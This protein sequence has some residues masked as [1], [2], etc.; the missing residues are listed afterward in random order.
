MPLCRR[1][2]DGS[3]KVQRRIISTAL[4]TLD[5][6]TPYGVQK[7][8]VIPILSHFL[9]ALPRFTPG[10]PLVMEIAE[11]EANIHFLCSTLTYKHGAVS[12][13][14]KRKG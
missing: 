3:P 14:F 4:F 10:I 2:D 1:T 5:I 12:C 8:G 11:I 7:T 9:S 13:W 6:A